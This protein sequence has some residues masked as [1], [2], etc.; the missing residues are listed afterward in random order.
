[1]IEPNNTGANKFLAI[2]YREQK[3]YEKAAY[4]A[5]KLRR[6]GIEPP[7]DFMKSIGIK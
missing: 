2:Y 3:D 1:M 4:Y 7:S 6:M 5:R